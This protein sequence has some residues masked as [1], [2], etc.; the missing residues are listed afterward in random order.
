MPFL[1]R[2][3]GIIFLTNLNRRSQKADIRF[4]RVFPGIKY[5]RNISF[6]LIH[7]LIAISM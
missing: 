2:N 1:Q 3:I 5:L 4:S 6:M 7:A